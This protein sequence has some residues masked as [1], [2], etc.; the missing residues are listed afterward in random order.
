MT[1][2][3]T[4]ART[5]PTRNGNGTYRRDLDHVVRD[6]EACRLASQG[7]SYAAI[8]RELG[9]STKGDAYKAVQRV[10]WETAREHGTEELR[11]KQLAELAEVRQKMWAILNDPPPAVD[12]LGRPVTT[13]DGEQV[14]DAQAQIQAAAVII[15]AS[16]RSARLTGTDAPK[17]SM[18]VSAQIESIPIADLRLHVEQKQRE[19]EAVLAR[20]KAGARGYVRGTVEAP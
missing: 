17:R 6:A 13:A 19:L 11:Q 9:Y 15:R 12:R 4:H 20:E 7:L 10:L 3:A 2:P 1:E 16:E 8:A 18:S 14:P 5:N